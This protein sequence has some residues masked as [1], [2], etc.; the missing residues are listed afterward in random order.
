VIALHE[1]LKPERTI[2]E[3]EASLFSALEPGDEGAP[4]DSR[5]AA[6]DRLVSSSWY[7]RLA[8]GVPPSIHTSFIARGLTSSDEGWVLDVAAGSCVPSASA[9]ATTSRPLVVLDRSLGML[10]RG[11]ARLRQLHGAIPP[12][13]ALMQADTHALPFRTGSMATVVCHGAFHVFS[14]PSDVCAEWVRVLR[15]GGRLYV[16]SLVQGRWLGDHY[17]GLLHRAGEVTHPRSAA[18]FAGFVEGEVGAPAQRE[19]I[20]NFAYL[21]LQVP[22]A[23]AAQQG[24]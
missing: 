11:M 23:P 15:S 1:V 12:H 8:W 7:S 19:A 14:S 10:R 16:S 5:A 2:R 24:S 22:G 13:I 6:Y 18:E 21:S 3:L 9:Y 17:L 4:Y 20:G